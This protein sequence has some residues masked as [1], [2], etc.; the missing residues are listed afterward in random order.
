[1]FCQNMNS[2]RALGFWRYPYAK[3]QEDLPDPHD[4]V[5]C[6]WIPSDERVN[7]VAYLKAGA[8]YETWR[9]LSHCRFRCGVPDREMGCHDFTDG[10]WVWPQGLFH[11]IDKHDVMLPDEFVDH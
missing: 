9:G 5:R 1:M 7:L 6:N 10:V 11:Y 8:T 3:G 2:P 4:L